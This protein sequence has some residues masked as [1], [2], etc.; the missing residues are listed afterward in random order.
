VPAAAQHQGLVQRPLELPVA[1]LHVAV[2]MRPRR[3]D[4]LPLQT[5]VPQQR[6]V[7]ELKGP[8]IAAGGTAAVNASVR[9]TRGTPPSSARAFCRPSLR[10]SKLSAKQ[11]V[12]ASQFE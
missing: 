3:V 9:C 10:L 12:P 8:P 7:T 1:L 11:T 2:L 4:R 6:L 5:V